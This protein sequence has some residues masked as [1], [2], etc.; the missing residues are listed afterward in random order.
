MSLSLMDYFAMESMTNCTLDVLNYHYP[1]IIMFK[2]VALE[3]FRLRGGSHN[4]FLSTRIRFQTQALTLRCHLRNGNAKLVCHET[5]NAKDH[6]SSEKRRQA[7][8]NGD[9]ERISEAIVMEAIIGG[10]RDQS[11]PAR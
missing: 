5:N 3:T 6:E 4:C 7:I 9:H 8:A 1:I 2:Q 10:E 11:T